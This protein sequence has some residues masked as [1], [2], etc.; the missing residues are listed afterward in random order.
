MNGKNDRDIKN[1]GRLPFSGYWGH[2]DTELQ[3]SPMERARYEPTRAPGGLGMT[4]QMVGDSL[5][6]VEAV[7]IEM[8]SRHDVEQLSTSEQDISRCVLQI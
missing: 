5:R 2:T 6:G 7:V 8:M 4:W 3:P 1:T